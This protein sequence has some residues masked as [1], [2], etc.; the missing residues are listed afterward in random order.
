[1]D[2]NEDLEHVVSTASAGTPIG[3][4]AGAVATLATAS[5][6]AS[7]LDAWAGLLRLRRS[8][9][10]NRCRA[11]GAPPRS[12]LSF[13]RLARAIRAGD[14]LDWRPEEVLDVMDER[15]LRSLLERGGLAGF[16]F[17][18]RPPLAVLFTDH[19]FPLPHCG[20]VVLARL[21]DVRGLNFRPRSAPPSARSCD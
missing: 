10:C 16:R 3:R 14:A 15:T 8:T 17:G 5:V 20:I 2:L 7:S 4:W 13:G 11:A 12:S 1:M 19:R 21:L 9:L 18:P 6:D